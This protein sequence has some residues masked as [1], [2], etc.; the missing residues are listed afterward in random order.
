MAM[1][2]SRLVPD[3]LTADELQACSELFDEC[4]VEMLVD[5]LVGPALAATPDPFG[6]PPAADVWGAAAAGLG[7]AETGTRVVLDREGVVVDLSRTR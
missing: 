6:T 1:T 3:L 7:V 4:L 2:T 5:K